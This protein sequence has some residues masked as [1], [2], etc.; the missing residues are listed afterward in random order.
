MTKVKNTAD[1][2]RQGEM[3]TNS[4]LTSCLTLAGYGGKKGVLCKGGARSADNVRVCVPACLRTVRFVLVMYVALSPLSL[5]LLDE[6]MNPFFAFGTRRARTLSLHRTLIRRRN[7]CHS[8]VLAIYRLSFFSP[9]LSLSLS[10][11]SPQYVIELSMKGFTANSTTICMR[12]SFSVRS[13]S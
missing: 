10:F 3:M 6:S 13:R 1:G 7:D 9:S 4:I 5:G 8:P 12:S 2:G 11:Y